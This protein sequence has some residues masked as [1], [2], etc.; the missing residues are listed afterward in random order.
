MKKSKFLALFLVV[1]FLL[2]G[3]AEKNAQSSNEQ[4]TSEAQESIQQETEVQTEESVDDMME[5]MTFS[6]TS[7]DLSDDVAAKSASYKLIKEKF[8]VDFDLVYYTSSDFMEKTRIWMA[9][10]EMP[11]IMQTKVVRD[12]YSEYLSWVEQGLVREIPDL[13]PYPTLK[14]LAENA[15]TAPF[16]NADGHYAWISYNPELV[17]QPTTYGWYYRYDL[18]KE[19]GLAHDD[20]VYTWEEYLEILRALKEA[21]KDNADFVPMTMDGYLFPYATGVMQYTANYWE[22]YLLRDGEYVWG[23]DMPE[24]LEGIKFSRMLYE[25]ELIPQDIALFK[26]NEGPDKFKIGNAGLLFTAIAAN[27]AT[28]DMYKTFGELY[29]DLDPYEAIKPMKV[30]GPEGEEIWWRKMD[31]T[32]NNIVTLFNPDLTDEEMHRILS[33]MEYMAS[34]EFGE[35][36]LYGVEGEDFTMVDGERKYKTE[37]N[38]PEGGNPLLVF[39][40]V[41]T[42]PVQEKTWREW[43]GDENYDAYLEYLDFLKS[44][45][46]SEFTAKDY[47]IYFFAGEN[48]LKYGTYAYDCGQAAKRIIVGE[49]D[50]EKE[51]EDAK[52]QFRPNVEIVLEE[53]NSQLLK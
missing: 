29:P 18:V 22:Q 17:A 30:Y 15:E 36:A 26:G 31:G 44:V 23:M 49:G 43:F 48:Y 41:R 40:M 32:V 46:L 52:A 16:L 42:W 34:E 7:Y 12:N 38:G 4:K 2:G 14:K 47:D 19:L 3:C 5:K 8:N 45:E 35:I 39:D 50:V 21:H 6:L 37:T 28:V 11:D 53:L 1:T 10:G 24:T 13:T 20:H 27:G 33:M 9:T 51:W 25:E